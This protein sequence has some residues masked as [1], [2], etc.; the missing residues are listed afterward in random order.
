MAG[1]E[2]EFTL[3]SKALQDAFDRDAKVFLNRAGAYLRRTAKNSIRKRKFASAPG[4]PPSS[5]TGALKN[6][7]VY[8]VHRSYR[9][10]D[11]FPRELPRK[12][13]HQP[14]TL[15]HGGH[16][17]SYKNPRRVK[18]YIGSGAAIRI[19]VGKEVTGFQNIKYRVT[20][21]HIR[22]KA[23]LERANKLE[24]KIWGP[25]ILK[26]VYIRPR[27]YMQPAWVKTK[28]VINTFWRVRS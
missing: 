17:P 6:N 9:R 18:R 20:F 16:S 27:P 1:F 14:E 21:A 10:V 7:I 28:Q 23:Q 3:N 25:M 26:R 2:V 8:E 5:H 13:K 15:E 24:E 4:T 22:T 12:I 19:G 11:I